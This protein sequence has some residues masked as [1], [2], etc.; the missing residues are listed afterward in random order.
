[1]SRLDFGDFGPYSEFDG[2]RT[3]PKQLSIWGQLE[4]TNLPPLRGVLLGGIPSAALPGG[5]RDNGTFSVLIADGPGSSENR[6]GNGP[7][8]GHIHI[9]GQRIYMFRVLQ[10]LW[11]APRAN[12]PGPPARTRDASRA[13]LVAKR[14]APLELPVWAILKPQNM[15]RIS[16][17]ESV[18][19]PKAD[20]ANKLM[21]L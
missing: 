21:D 12:G 5:A 19:G 16:G 11:A 6:K 20:S 13:G 8:F 3:D 1:L 10:S 14:T 4:P 7:G 17:L 15:T 18:S 2:F 9:E